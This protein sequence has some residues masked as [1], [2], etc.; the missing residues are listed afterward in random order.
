M[1]RS[2]NRPF[3]TPRNRLGERHWWTDPAV[4]VRSSSPDQPPDQRQRVVSKVASFSWLACVISRSTRGCRGL[5]GLGREAG[6]DA[7]LNRDAQRL[8]I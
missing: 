1:A 6:G 4:R 2:S 7:T 3:S 5:A 8:V